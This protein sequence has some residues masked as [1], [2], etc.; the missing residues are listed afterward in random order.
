MIDERPV[1][2]AQ[3]PQDRVG[4]EGFA[5]VLQA[6]GTEAAGCEGRGVGYASTTWQECERGGIHKSIAIQFDT[7]HHVRRARRLL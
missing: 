1:V 5:F 4:G 6:M 3:E 2:R 7:H